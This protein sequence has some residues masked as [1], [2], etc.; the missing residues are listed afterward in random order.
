MRKVVHLEHFDPFS[1]ICF[2]LRQVLM[3][4]SGSLKSSAGRYNP[5]S[6]TARPAAC[7][8]IFKCS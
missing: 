2:K 1:R 8:H 3:P 5:N 7:F 6:Q 4:H